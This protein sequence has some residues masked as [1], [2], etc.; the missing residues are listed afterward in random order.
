MFRDEYRMLGHLKDVFPSILTLLLSAMVTPNILEY[1][2]VSLKL[3]PPSRIYRQPLDR[4]NL[5]YIVSPI[6]KSEFKDLDFLVP[7]GGAIGNISKTMI[8]VDSI[9]EAE[10]MAKHLQSRLPERV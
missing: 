3:S 6:R 9:D 8:F 7:S 2:R 5:T 1:I 4:S 10:K